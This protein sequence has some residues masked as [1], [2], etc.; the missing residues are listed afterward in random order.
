M[1][2]STAIRVAGYWEVASAAH[3]TPALTTI[4]PWILTAHVREVASAAFLGIVLVYVH[5]IR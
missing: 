2:V 5:S 1:P 3:P 4:I